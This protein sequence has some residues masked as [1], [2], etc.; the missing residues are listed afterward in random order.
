M[1]AAG[2]MQ[3]EGSRREKEMDGRRRG[4]RASK[5]GKEGDREGCGDIIR[6]GTDLEDV[7]WV[8]EG[9]RCSTLSKWTADGEAD[10]LAKEGGR[11]GSCVVAG[12]VGTWG[13][14]G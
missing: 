4:R 2:V 7:G 12:G 9:K 1:L 14:S 8:R 10:G 5:G 13:V 6:G 3:A 11:K